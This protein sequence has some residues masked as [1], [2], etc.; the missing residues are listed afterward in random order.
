VARLGG[1]ARLR[2]TAAGLFAEARALE[3]KASEVEE[4]LGKAIA[5]G[6]RAKAAVERLIGSAIDR[7]VVITGCDE[8]LGL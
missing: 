7:R 3:A 4:C 8:V 5:R 6:R 2:A 1:A